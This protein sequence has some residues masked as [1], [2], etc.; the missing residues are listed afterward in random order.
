MITVKL[1]GGLG[2]QLFQYAFGRAVSLKLETP[3][4][5]DITAFDNPDE[6]E[7]ERDFGLNCFNI[8]AKILNESSVSKVDFVKS[9]IDKTIRLIKNTLNPYSGYIFEPKNLE[10]KENATLEGSWQTEIIQD[11]GVPDF[12]LMMAADTDYTNT[13]WVTL[14]DPAKNPERGLRWTPPLFD[15]VP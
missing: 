9:K 15:P 11:H 3:L 7:T 13:V 14:G 6:M 10:A 4:N 12:A 8:Q 2:N 5:L 1:K